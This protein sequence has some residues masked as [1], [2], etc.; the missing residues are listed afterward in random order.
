MNSNVSTSVEV[1]SYPLDGV[2]GVRKLDVERVS[3][4]FNSRVTFYS[5]VT[6]IRRKLRDQQHAAVYHPIERLSGAK[7]V[8]VLDGSHRGVLAKV[9]SM[10]APFGNE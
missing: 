3:F 7:D 9:N 6:R 4:G 10:L 1:D 5:W 8:K 2:P